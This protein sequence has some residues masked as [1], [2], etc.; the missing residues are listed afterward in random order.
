MTSWT[1]K[2]F[3]RHK[4]IQR[5]ISNNKRKGGL[6]SIKEVIEADWPLKEKIT[7]IRHKYVW[8]EGNYELFHDKDGKYNTTKVRLNAVIQGIIEG[9]I[10]PGVLNEL[11]QTIRQW[12]KEQR[13]KK[14]AEEQELLDKMISTPERT[15]RATIKKEIETRPRYLIDIQKCTASAELTEYL[16][17]IDEYIAATP[18]KDRKSLYE[19]R[20]QTIKKKAVK[21]QKANGSNIPNISADKAFRQLVK[22]YNKQY[23]QELKK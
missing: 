21:W 3:D 12:N 19:M 10:D 11:N 1:K 13:I 17:L 4:Y 16:R 23:K 6:L 5:A 20:Y 8:Y 2:A 22:G 14:A 7:Y 18:E 15:L 9:K